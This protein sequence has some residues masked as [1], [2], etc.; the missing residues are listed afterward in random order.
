M[1][2]AEK[3][4]RKYVNLPADLNILLGGEWRTPTFKKYRI[5]LQNGIFSMS[6]IYDNAENKHVSLSH[7]VFSNPDDLD[8]QAKILLAISHFLRFHD[9]KINDIELV[10]RMENH[11]F[12][13]AKDAKLYFRRILAAYKN[14]RS[15]EASE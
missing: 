8:K 14:F 9:A 6:E 15:K 10:K 3:A 4:K 1:Q 2:I 13:V 7:A 12:I 5:I 11:A